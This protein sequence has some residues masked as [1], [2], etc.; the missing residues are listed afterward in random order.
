MTSKEL[1]IKTIKGENPGRTPVYG[2]LKANMEEPITKEFGSVVAFEDAYEFDMA[3]IFGGPGPFNKCIQHLRDAGET[4]TPEMLLDIDFDDIDSESDYENVKQ[5]MA[6]HRARDRFCYMQTPGIFEAM[7][8]V[9]GIENHLLYLALYPDELQE[10]YTKLANWNIKNAHHLMDLGM[11]DIHISD[12]WGSQKSMM[13]SPAMHEELIVPHHKRIVA[14]C[15]KR[16]VMTSLHSDGCITP[17]LESVVDIG[18]DFIHPWQENCNMPY[19]LYLEK[20]RDKFAILG[21]VCV[22]STLGFG[23][24]ERLES[25]IRRVFDLLKGQRW[26]CCTTHYVQNSCSIEEL[27]FAYDLIRKLANN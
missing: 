19:S 10:V 13:F 16:G 6:H 1:V 23:K 11:D 3:H 2:W 20:Y 18:Y 15:K 7:N 5:E 4:I 12:D 22:Q 17:A 24:Y 9:F 25:E 8:G 27:I 21:G 14:E 26:M